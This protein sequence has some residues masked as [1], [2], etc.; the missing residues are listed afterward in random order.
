MNN[1][2]IFLSKFGAILFIVSMRYLKK[3]LKYFK[4]FSGSKKEVRV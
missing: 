1:F 3:D 2:L 4:E